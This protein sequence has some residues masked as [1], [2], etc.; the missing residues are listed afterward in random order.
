MPPLTYLTVD[1]VV[2]GVGTSQVLPYVT[3]LAAR[4]LPVTLH[5]FEPA[6]PPGELVDDLRRAGVDW[7][8]HRFRGGGSRGGVGRVLAG[9]VAVRGRPLVHCRST[10]PAASALLGRPG[11]WVWDRRDFWLDERIALG[12]V[13]PGS[14]QDHVLRRVEHAAAERADAVITLTAAAVGVLERRHPGFERQRATVVP[15]CVDLDRFAPAPFVPP[16][17]IV[18][19]FSGS[20]N[21]R[22][23][24][25]VASRLI[26]H[27]RAR[28]A[29]PV[30]VRVLRP[31]GSPDT[32]GVRALAAAGA[33]VGAARFEDMPD[34]LRATHVGFAI[35]RRDLP[36][37][38]AGGAPTKIAEFLA[39]GRPVVVSAGLGDYGE[40]LPAHRA[41]VV[42]EGDTEADLDRAA[43]EVLA[44]LADP[45]TPERCRGLAERQFG[46]DHA[47]DLL[48]D[49]YRRASGEA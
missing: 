45:A 17:P 37:V 6:H 39:C 7:H 44:L 10:L 26:N 49:V 29:G 31:H 1:S 48:M 36:T 32:P 28:A 21:E 3:R 4:G 42:L 35:L 20:F 33:T 18:V 34:E 2:T 30:A 41:G 13:V 16:D 14:A 25:P 40:L 23:D 22:Y 24:A 15:T 19:M 46:L 5:S 47:V 12:S 9:A 43:G 11:A 8:P 27:L 38:T